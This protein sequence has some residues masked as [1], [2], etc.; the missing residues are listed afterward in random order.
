MYIVCIRRAG[1]GTNK[2]NKLIYHT[3]PEGN[4]G[5]QSVTMSDHDVFIVVPRPAVQLHTST[6]AAEESSKG[7]SLTTLGKMPGDD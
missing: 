1:Q 4:F 3:Y 2:S 6:Q 7:Q 5:A